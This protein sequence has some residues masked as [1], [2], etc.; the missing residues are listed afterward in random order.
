MPANDVSIRWRKAH[1]KKMQGKKIAG[2]LQLSM[3]HF[4]LP[5]DFFARSLLPVENGV[6]LDAE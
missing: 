1:G 4:F 3:D 2:C 6:S 5:L